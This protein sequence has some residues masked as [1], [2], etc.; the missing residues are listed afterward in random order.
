M[1]V[2]L[3]ST[4]SVTHR[5][6]NVPCVPNLVYTDTWN[7]FYLMEEYVAR[8]FGGSAQL[9]ILPKQKAMLRMVI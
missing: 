8:N 5:T 9:E 1:T 3:K 6:S 2:G 7:L 4:R